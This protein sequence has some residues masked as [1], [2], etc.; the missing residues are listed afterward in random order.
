MFPLPDLILIDGGPGQLS[1]A[2]EALGKVGLGHLP[3]IGLAKARGE[4]EERIYTPGR[5][6][7]TILHPSAASTH[8]LQQIRDEAHRFAITYHRKLRGK[9]FVPIQQGKI[10]GKGRGRPKNLMTNLIRP[11]SL[12]ARK[13]KQHT[14]AV[15]SNS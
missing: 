12:V 9:A 14:R 4:K 2:V 6:A 10:K 5:S 8:L 1:A 7:P 11:D 3:I 15:E 13:R